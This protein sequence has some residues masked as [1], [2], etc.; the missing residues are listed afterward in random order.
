MYRYRITRKENLSNFYIQMI[1]YSMKRRKGKFFF[2]VGCLHF[3]S[4]DELE[5]FNRIIRQIL[6]VSIHFSI[7]CTAPYVLFCF[8]FFF[9]ICSMLNRISAVTYKQSQSHLNFILKM[10]INA[11][12]SYRHVIIRSLNI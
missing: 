2:M 1:R 8:E 11:P 7:L 3:E 4:T 5:I 12:M 9:Q 10:R 6:L